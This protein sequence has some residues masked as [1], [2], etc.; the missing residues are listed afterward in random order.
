MK[1]LFFDTETTGLPKDWNAPVHNLDNWP[2]LVQL[3][4][5]TYDHSGNLIEEHE[6]IIKPE[7][8]SIP[9]EASNIHKITNTKA[10]DEGVEL[11]K[12]L[13][14]FKNSIEQSHLLVAHNYKYDYSIMGSELLRNGL[15]N[16]LISKDHVCTMEASTDY[17]KIDGPYGYKWPKLEE[18]Y[19]KLFQGN[20]NAHNALDDIRACAKCFWKLNKLGIIHF[21]VIK[22]TNVVESELPK[23]KNNS[24]SLVD[25]I[26]SLGA[27][28]AKIIKETNTKNRY[29]IVEGTE[30]R[31]KVA[32]E[33]KE[34]QAE[35]RVSWIE[36]NNEEGGYYLIHK[37]EDDLIEDKSPSNLIALCEVDVQIIIL[38]ILE[39][40]D[41]RINWINNK[42]HFISEEGELELIIY[43]LYY[44]FK[45][46]IYGDYKELKISS[47]IITKVK[48]NDAT[49]HEIQRSSGY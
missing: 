40:K 3:A 19:Y 28:T 23:N 8:F 22:E 44:V 7:G 4:W 6:Y 26:I 18:L 35:N 43:Y 31:G 33:V 5:Q 37:K 41:K 2:R 21:N 14:L 20:F 17:C 24:Q 15:D 13:S 36:Y 49:I 30:V 29:F 38:K 34:L 16:N 39:A 48:V 32:N 11:K 42:H 27:N 9:L 45:S 10:I 1:L 46:L 25:F 47:T 12:V